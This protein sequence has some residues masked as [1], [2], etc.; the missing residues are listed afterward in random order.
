ML[1]LKFRQ[2]SLLLGEYT[3]VTHSSWL[4]SSVQPSGV[5]ARGAWRGGERGWGSREQKAG[6]EA[7]GSRQA[8]K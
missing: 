7:A 5:E 1:D 8:Q 3:C 2:V 6:E 4:G